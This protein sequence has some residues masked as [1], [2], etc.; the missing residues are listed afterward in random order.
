MKYADLVWSVTELKRC[1]TTPDLRETFTKVIHK[2]GFQQFAYVRFTKNSVAVEVSIYTFSEAWKIVY[3]QK[4]YDQIDPV[5]VEAFNKNDTFFWSACMPEFTGEHQVFFDEAASYGIFNGL[6]TPL[7]SDAKAKAIMTIA[8]ARTKENKNLKELP[9]GIM[10]YAKVI[11]ECFHQV[12]LDIFND[13][14]VQLKYRQKQV[15]TMASYGMSSREIAAA[16]D[17]SEAYI[18][19]LITGILHKLGTQSRPAAVRRAQ[20]LGLL[21]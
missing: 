19:E 16:L 7:K 21:D 18:N 10:A 15:L 4:G 8:A 5:F 20:E 11:S 2:L 9:A 12:A 14:N 3:F 1:K 6:T 13:Q 17:K